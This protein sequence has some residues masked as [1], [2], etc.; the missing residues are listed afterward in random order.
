MV[1]VIASQV[2]GDMRCG[3]ALKWPNDVLIAGGK[4]SG[5]LI[6]M[7]GSHF[8][9]GIGCN[10]N[11]SPE[12]KCTGAEGARP[13]THVMRHR[14][15]AGQSPTAAQ[16]EDAEQQVQAAAESCRLAVAEGILAAFAGWLVPSDARMESAADIVATANALLSRDIQL[17]RLDR[18]AEGYSAAGR[19]VRPLRVNPDGTLQVVDAA[20]GVQEALI[21]DYLW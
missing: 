14:L 9:V 20:T 19:E 11:S 13:A 16:D 12:I 7:E 4:A 6:E 3:V 2:H 18:A 1:S 15:P 17:V 10:I 21:T 5:V 8:V